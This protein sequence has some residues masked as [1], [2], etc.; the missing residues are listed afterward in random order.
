M[1]VALGLGLERPLGACPVS[2]FSTQSRAEEREEESFRI[3]R[4][5]GGEVFQEQ[6]PRHQHGGASQPVGRGPPRWEALLL[7]GCT[8][9]SE[10]QT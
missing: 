10:L 7:R 1:H 6:D 3:R 2:M 5:E 8:A 9:G 4:K